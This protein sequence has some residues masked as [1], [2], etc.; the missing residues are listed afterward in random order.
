MSEYFKWQF[1]IEIEEVDWPSVHNDLTDEVAA[2]LADTE[3][4]TDLISEEG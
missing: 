4:M 1:T 2:L 3:F